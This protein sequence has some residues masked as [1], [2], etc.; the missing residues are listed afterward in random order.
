MMV[1]RSLSAIPYGNAK[2][3]KYDDGTIVLQSYQTDVAVIDST[4]VLTING[5]YSATTRKHIGAF[6]KEY[7]GLNYQLAKMLY[8]DNC[9][10]NIYTGEVIGL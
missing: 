1:I 10:Y 2:V 5:L 3:R 9:K 7:A 8:N 4:G 6:V